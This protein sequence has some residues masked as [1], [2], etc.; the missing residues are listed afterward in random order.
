MRKYYLLAVLFMA[1][2]FCKAQKNSLY[3]LINILKNNLI[4]SSDSLFHNTMMNESEYFFYCKN[5]KWISDSLV[6]KSQYEI[7]K[8]HTSDSHSRLQKNIESRFKHLTFLNY[9]TTPSIIEGKSRID[10]YLSFI[11]SSFINNKL[12]D[13]RLF[14]KYTLVCL[15]DSTFKVENYPFN[16]FDSYS[17]KNDTYQTILKYNQHYRFDQNSLFAIG[18]GNFIKDG[19]IPY[20]SKNKWGFSN[21]K[22]K[23]LTPNLWDNL[24]AFDT[25]YAIVYQEKLGY[26]IIDTNLKLIYTTYPKS[27]VYDQHINNDGSKIYII[28]NKESFNNKR[29]TG[30]SSY[31]SEQPRKIENYP[32]T[33]AYQENKITYFDK[34]NFTYAVIKFSNQSDTILAERSLIKAENDFALIDQEDSIY[35]YYQNLKKP[36]FKS[37]L[38]CN[39][40]K[41]GYIILY[42]SENLLFGLFDFQTKKFIKPEFK[43]IKRY[44]TSNNKIFYQVKTKENRIG[45]LTTKGEKLYDFK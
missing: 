30:L 28:N 36:I 45:Y 43:D 14:F 15:I 41:N 18:A 23:K 27:I 25:K 17:F 5:F 44:K 3:E 33:K 6:A 9:Y 42:D 22:G 19:I 24:T 4:Q 8:D 7:Y 11:D 13:K 1:L 29:A 31:K 16:V 12:K 2:N 34:N 10:L 39:E 40:L 20:C 26:N 35:L 21:N 37:N 32:K 38:F